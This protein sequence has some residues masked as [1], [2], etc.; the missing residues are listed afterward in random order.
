MNEQEWREM[1]DRQIEEMGL[2]STGEKTCPIPGDEGS[3]R[4]AVGAYMGR[5]VINFG[6]PLSWAAMKPDQAELFI[7][8]IQESLKSIQEEG[9]THES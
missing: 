9:T 6:R 7:A 3:L 5:I 4:T 2:G 8:A 1:M